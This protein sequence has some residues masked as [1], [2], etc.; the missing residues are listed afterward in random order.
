MT[1]APP[2]PARVGSDTDVPTPA[3]PRAA[4]RVPR[5]PRGDSVRVPGRLARWLVASLAVTVVGDGLIVGAGIARARALSALSAGAGPR[6]DAVRAPDAWLVLEGAQLV[7]LLVSGV[8]FLIWMRRLY[9]NVHA[10]AAPEP[11]YRPGWAVGSWFVPLA[12]VVVPKQIVNDIWLLSETPWRDAGS[13]PYSRAKVPSWIGWWWAAVLLA[14]ILG[15]GAA[16]GLDTPGLTPS[17]AQAATLAVVAAAA[18]EILAGALA[19]RLVRSLT[20]R[21]RSGLGG[22][23]TRPSPGPWATRVAVV[24]SAAAA[25]V[26]L[27]VAWPTDVGTSTDAQR[28]GSSVRT[29]VSD[30]DVGDCIEDFADIDRAWVVVVDCDV[31]HRAEKIASTE[32]SGTG[33]PDDYPGDDEIMHEADLFCLHAFEAFVGAPYEW[34]DLELYLFH[35]DREGWERGDRRVDCVAVAMDG[36]DDLVATV[37]GRGAGQ[38]I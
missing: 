31:P 36:V 19:I 30:L 11:R 20:E 6:A 7:A 35:P 24:A 32:L 29:P 12:N 17:A 10:A 25:A 26:A 33:G 22:A 13:V 8:L 38:G 1:A 14:G 23:E 34:S 4:D 37:H 15:A 9:R 5:S 2:D 27:L 21:Q 16:D 3:P 28:G 18:A